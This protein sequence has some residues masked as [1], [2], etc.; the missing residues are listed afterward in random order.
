MLTALRADLGAALGERLRELLDGR[1]VEETA[2]RVDQLL[3]DPRFPLPDTRRPV[4]PWPP[5]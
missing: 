3:A 2:K 4:V 5:F 1:E